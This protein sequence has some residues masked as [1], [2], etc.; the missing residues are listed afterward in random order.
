MF[1]FLKPRELS[2]NTIAH[3][4]IDSILYESILKLS[5]DLQAINIEG[6]ELLK[7]FS[8]L[9]EDVFYSLYKPWPELIPRENIAP[10]FT[11]NLQEIEKLLEAPSYKDLRQYTQLDEFSAGLGSKALLQELCARLKDDKALQEAAEQINQ[12][13]GQQQKAEDLQKKLEQMQKQGQRQ[14]QRQQP[15]QQ[16]KS[17]AKTSLI[18]LQSLQQQIQQVQEAAQQ[19]ANKA[20]Q[21]MA[22]SQSQ[23][24]RAITAAAEKATTECEETEGILCSWGFDQGQ[25]Q[26]LPFDKK[27]ELVKV[28]REQD[29]FKNMAKL[30]GRM[31][32]I[33]LASRK[34]KLD[35]MRVELHSITTGDDIAHALT[36][37]LVTLRRLAL[38][39][40]L[41][42]KLHEKQLLQ[43][44]LNHR[45]KAGRGPIV[46]LIDSSGSMH[47]A[48]DEWAKAVAIGLL[49]IAIKERRPFSY[50]IFSS[51]RDELVTDTFLPSDRSPEKV[52]NMVTVYLGGGTNFEKPLTWATNKI[53]ESLFNKADIVMITDGECA[54]SDKFL[55]EFLSLKKAK[56]FSVYS[57]LIGQRAYELQRWSDEVFD[58]TDLLDDNVP[59]QLFNSI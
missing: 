33:A 20:Q 49:E 6:T 57:I 42:R 13:A 29:K 52:M 54:V 18:P 11:L 40:N 19:S 2:R 46:C 44:E 7:T 32:N 25:F 45:D 35:H 48:K 28:L 8:H 27:M 12:A 56:E 23:L 50:A 41:Y 9:Q 22:S 1:D 34:S 53:S 36:Q 55:A 15:Q 31:R 16:N 51:A 39:L 5:P 3:D 37:E 10:E 26:R 24:R 47:G 59:E 21:I 4:G 43:Y 30:V 17:T 58:V 14:G 38:K